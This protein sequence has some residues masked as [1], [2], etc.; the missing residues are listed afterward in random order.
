M[1]RPG[2]ERLTGLVE[3]DE[4]YVDDV[5]KDSLI[6]FIETAVEP[7][8]SVHTDGWQAYWTVP[9]HGYE[10][11]RTI[12]RGQHDPAHV[13]MPRVDRV[14]SLL[15][16]WMLGTH[17]GSVGPRAPRRVPQRVHIPL[18]PT[19]LPPARPALLPTTRAGR[20][21]RP[22]HLPDRQPTPRPPTANASDPI[23]AATRHRAALAD[24]NLTQIDTPLHA[25]G[26][27]AAPT[28][29]RSLSPSRRSLEQRDRR[30]CEFCNG[31]G[32]V[33]SAAA[34]ARPRRRARSRS[35]ARAPRG[36]AALPLRR[37]RELEAC[38]HHGGLVLEFR[39]QQSPS[40]RVAAA[41]HVATS[42]H[43]AHRRRIGPIVA[44]VRLQWR[45]LR[46]FR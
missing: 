23:P 5:S 20:H 21:H 13:L 14:A 36:D 27:V 29:A 25:K 18:Q 31:T 9:D 40:P 17:Q 10:H 45:D 12:I 35:I 26:L 37:A 6:A 34:G 39:A 7:G 3:V 30:L 38:K 24:L 22:H 33:L 11:E 19:P 28:A 44:R 16:R 15:K 46:H 41:L 43:A 42:A 1:V 2:R 8:A 32:T 4:T